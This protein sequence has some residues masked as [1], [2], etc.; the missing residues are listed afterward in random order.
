MRSRLFPANSASV[1]LRFAKCRPQFCESCGATYKWICETFSALQSTS[2]PVTDVVHTTRCPNQCIIGDAILP[3]T[4]TKLTKKRGSKFGAVVAPSDAKEKKRNI[5][6]QSI[7]RNQTTIHPVYNCSK[8]FLK[9]YFLYDFWCAQ[10]CT[11]RA[12]FGP[13]MRNLTLAI[14][15]M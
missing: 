10:T 7:E 11:F 9:I 15:A 4:D 3:Q 14:S 8:R 5:G 2:G 13:P 1:C 6:V 12:V